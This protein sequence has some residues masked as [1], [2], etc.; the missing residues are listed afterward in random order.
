[1]TESVQTSLRW[2][3]DWPW[4]VGC[5]A[6][7]LLSGAAWLL[8]WREVGLLARWLRWTLP[9]L[10]AAAVA[11]AV[12]MLSGPVLHHRKTIGELS[13]LFLYVDGSRSMDLTD[14]AMEP[15]RKI[16]VL[17]R[18]GLLKAGDAPMDLPLGSEAMAEAQSIA[19]TSKGAQ[20]AET[21]EWNRILTDFSTKA[22]EARDHAARSSALPPDRLALLTQELVDPAR[23]LAGREMR[24]IDDRK[25][26]GKDLLDLAAIASRWR[27]EMNEAFNTA[28]A[29]PGIS[30][31]VQV[32]LKRFDTIPRWQ[33][34]Q[35]L[36][37]EGSGDRLL[38]KLS[39][40][41]EVQMLSLEAPEPR[42]L[43]Q[44]TASASALPATLPQP[45]GEVT[46]LTAALTASASGTVGKHAVVVFSD[47]QHND[48]ESPVD[49]AKVLAGREVPVFTVG[50]GSQAPPRD[51]AVMKVEAP[52][53]VFSEDRVRGQVTVNDAMPPGQDFAIQ[54]KDGERVL[55]E[56]T[57][58][59]DGKGMRKVSFD[60]AVSE[61]VKEK[62]GRQRE[63]VQTANVPLEVAVSIS[64]LTGDQ[65]VS[66]NTAALRVRAVTQRRRILL[67][68]GRPRW[69]SRYLRNLFARDE[70]WEMQSAFVGMQSGDKGLPRGKG[71][72]VFPD[73]PSLL[74]GF[75]LIIIGDVPADAFRPDEL[76]ALR[77]FVGQRGGA[78]VFID[79]PRGRLREYAETPLGPVLPVEWKS[80][81]IRE[82]VT[83]LQLAGRAQTLAPFALFPD[84]LQNAATWQ[85]LPPPRWL[86]G[87]TPL[88][89]AEVL[90][91]AEV[92]GAPGGRVP[93]AIFRPF[94]AGR[95]L[96]HAFDESWRWRYEVGD[97]HHVKFW[98]QAA[99]WI[100]EIPFAVRDKFVSLD[101]GA[102]TYRPGETADFRVRLRDGEGKAVTNAV[103]DAI[104]YRDGKKAG[105][106]RLSPDE[107]AGG[108]FRGRTGALEPGQYEVAVESPAIAER[109]TRARGEFKVEPRV[110][111]ELS[112]LA[113]N[114]D[115]LKQVSAA[116]GGQYLREEQ[117][118][119]L[120]E[121]LAP[122]TQGR[123]QE[124]DTP[125]WQSYWWFVPLILLLSVEWML[126][127]RAGML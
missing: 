55:W 103:V 21:S 75:D 15:A 113:L 46:N 96:Y 56:Q 28:L 117:I 87:A 70:Q 106:I 13:K 123:I 125:L 62:L 65:E 98:N 122:L 88:P 109:D 69:E 66:N 114:E 92:P 40:T 112:R 8:Y 67:V 48:G 91:E 32:A 126:R 90:L 27:A 53:S 78:M 35:S 74:A 76:E 102:I 68:D 64:A 79:G 1:M 83:R 6:A 89:G 2:V 5:L 127:K 34:L 119:R 14:A 54:V 101:A 111:E 50:F 72:D 38:G 61:M 41:H 115:L 85:G 59:T 52:E 108:L 120:K 86:S 9:T 84:A 71:S 116:S 12:L 44:P 94:G 80:A 60:F 45:V 124:I 51:L 73:D 24:A 118:D 31:A 4:W 37:L 100:A 16:R 29:A 49:A 22:A 26:A 82:A 105:T 99:N 39:E 43:W 25:R 7:V 17:E 107:N 47:G 3:G 30:S 18:L 23:A 33:R 95:V 121:L 81:P 20:G 36:L 104:L 77:D 10:R 110:S 93:A 97:L 57:L 19:E 58:K 63:G 42:R 11:M